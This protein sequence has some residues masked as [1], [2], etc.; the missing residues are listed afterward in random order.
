MVE[1]LP[2]LLPVVQ[3]ALLDLLSLVLAKKAFRR[4]T[5]L[6]YQKALAAAIHSGAAT[7][8]SVIGD[9]SSAGKQACAGLYL[10]SC[11]C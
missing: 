1:A 4:D 11:G 9:H 10:V 3:G 6:Q 7:A 8:I 2:E 5:P